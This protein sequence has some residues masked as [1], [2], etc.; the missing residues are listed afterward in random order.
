MGQLLAMISHEVKQPLAATITLADAGQ[1]FLDGADPKVDEARQVFS[2][3]RQGGIRANDVLDRIRSLVKKAP[4]Q[5][6]TLDINAAIHDVVA[7][8]R[9]EASRKGVIMQT[10]LCGALPLVEGDRVQLQQ[11]VLNLVF[12][13][14]EAMSENYDG[15]R[16]LVISTSQSDDE[17]VTVAVSDTGPGVTQADIERIFEPFYTTKTSGMGMGLSICRSIVEAHGGMLRAF[18][19]PRRGVTFEASIPTKKWDAD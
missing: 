11:V 12:N 9:A 10:Q 16:D 17:S 15:P 8:S 14:I 5:K 3:I 18:T 1:R 2:R 4:P 7:L 19:N 13:A 6:E